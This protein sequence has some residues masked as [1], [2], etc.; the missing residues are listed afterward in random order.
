MIHQS[1]STASN[2]L[3]NYPYL[4]L[5]RFMIGCDY[6]NEWFRGSC[7]GIST[8]EASSIETY[9]CPTCCKECIEDPFYIEGINS[10][11]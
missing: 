4:F 3:L 9:K 8:V 1:K 6:C 7:V 10:F 11:T 2:K 5:S